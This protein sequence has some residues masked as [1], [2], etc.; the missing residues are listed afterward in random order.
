[1]QRCSLGSCLLAYS[2]QG[3]KAIFQAPGRGKTIFI[4]SPH[5]GNRGEER[6][7]HWELVGHPSLQCFF[8]QLYSD[9]PAPKVLISHGKHTRCRYRAEAT[10][11][12]G[13]LTDLKSSV[14][15]GGAGPS[16]TDHTEQMARSPG[17][18]LSPGLLV[19]TAVKHLTSLTSLTPKPGVLPH[20]L[21][22]PAFL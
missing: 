9:R 20:S 13:A 21:M 1:M 2:A 19:L 18:R 17:A 16:T 22:L 12:D 4:P 10:N 3:A 15:A 14:L 6:L 8:S 11:G 7:G 5:S